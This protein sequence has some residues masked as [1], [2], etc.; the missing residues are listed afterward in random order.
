MVLSRYD[1]IFAAQY[2]ANVDDDFSF[3]CCVED[4]HEAEKL[5]EYEG[6]KIIISNTS[7]TANSAFVTSIATSSNMPSRPTL[8]PFFLPTFTRS[9]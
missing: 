4:D 6:I 1:W 7:T 3:L 2:V 5:G 8:S 9:K